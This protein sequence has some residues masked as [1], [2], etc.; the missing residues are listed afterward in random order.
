M[1]QIIVTTSYQFHQSIVHP[2]TLRTVDHIILCSTTLNFIE[3]E[4]DKLM[5]YYVVQKCQ[6][7]YKINKEMANNINPVITSSYT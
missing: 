5:D 3:T 4:V 2:R 6:K 7:K 1:Q